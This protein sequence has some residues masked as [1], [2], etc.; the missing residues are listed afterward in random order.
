MFDVRVVLCSENP[1]Q[2][3][4][5]PIAKGRQRSIGLLTPHGQQTSLAHNRKVVCNWHPQ[6]PHTHHCHNPHRPLHRQAQRNPQ[7][8]TKGARAHKVQTR[9]EPN[10]LTI[11][12][13][14]RVFCEQVCAKKTLWRV[15]QRRV[16]RRYHHHLLFA[17]LVS[18]F[19]L[20]V[21]MSESRKTWT[22]TERA[23]NTRVPIKT[24]PRASL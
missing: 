14:R 18:F 10:V 16:A 6:S 22:T 11:L 5:I 20:F 13:N 8:E 7:I 2:F 3:Y 21:P 17:F 1:P 12:Y 19:V 9:M 23:P 24:V 15:R 4:N